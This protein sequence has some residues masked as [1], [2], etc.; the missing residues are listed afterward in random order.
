MRESAVRSTRSFTFSA[1][2]IT[3]EVQLRDSEFH[4]LLNLWTKDP[5][6]ETV[7]EA[8]EMIPYVPIKLGAPPDRDALRAGDRAAADRRGVIGDGPCQ[9]LGGGR[10]GGATSARRTFSRRSAVSS[11]S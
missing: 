6:P 7:Q 8:Y 1:D 5:L 11:S 3:C 9:A 4:D 2:D 10:V